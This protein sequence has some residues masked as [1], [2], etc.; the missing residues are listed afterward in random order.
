MWS[1]FS[2]AFVP[3]SVTT[4]PFTVISPEVII[5][6]ARRREVIPARAIIFCRRSSIELAASL[7][8]GIQ[9]NGNGA[10]GEALRLLAVAQFPEVVEER[11]TAGIHRHLTG[12]NW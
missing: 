4:W 11:T 6:S 7:P 1:R 3:S 5:S 9:L 2:S 12:I 10:D 8:Q